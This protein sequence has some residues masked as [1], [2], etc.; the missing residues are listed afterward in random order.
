M[1]HYFS[2]QQKEYYVRMCSTPKPPTETFF[3]P[4][5]PGRHA[6]LRGGMD[7][8]TSSKE[9]FV[10][11]YIW[12][13]GAFSPQLIQLWNVKPL[14]QW[15]HYHEQKTDAFPRLCIMLI[16]RAGLS[17]SSEM[18]RKHLVNNLAFAE[19]KV[20]R[21]IQRPPHGVRWITGNRG[22]RAGIPRVCKDIQ[23]Y[24]ICSKIYVLEYIFF[25]NLTNESKEL[26]KK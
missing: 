2:R 12:I 25:K 15:V 16:H 18:Q 22:N 26:K 20:G 23:S 21:R 8:V 10:W 9:G 13:A 24:K 4:V 6:L 19:E 14:H 17:S 5:T 3:G 11:V 7:S 1:L